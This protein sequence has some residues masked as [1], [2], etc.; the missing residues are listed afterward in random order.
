MPSEGGRGEADD[1]GRVV[2][3]ATHG[4]G[5]AGL[6]CAFVTSRNSFLRWIA[7]SGD[8]GNPGVKSHSGLMPDAL[9][10]LAHFAVSSVMCFANSAGVFGAIATA[11]SS[12]RR[13]LIVGSLI[14]PL[15][16]L[17]S[18]SMIT[19]GVFLGTPKPTHAFAS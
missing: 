12:E 15:N 17:L 18:V 2:R 3:K 13:F 11:P 19:G 10:T 1:G 8:D 4:N 6:A 14:A 7:R 9:I 16:S 5:C